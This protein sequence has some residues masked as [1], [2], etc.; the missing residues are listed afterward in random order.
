M[1]KLTFLATNFTPYDDFLKDL[2]ERLNEVYPNSGLLNSLTVTH[3]NIPVFVSKVQEADCTC[4]KLKELFECYK[5]NNYCGEEVLEIAEQLYEAKKPNDNTFAV[6]CFIF[7]TLGY[8]KDNSHGNVVE[9]NDQ[10]A[11]ITVNFGKIEAMISVVLH[12]LFVIFAEKK[13]MVEKNG[14]DEHL[15]CNDIRCFMHPESV[16][17]VLCERCEERLHI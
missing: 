2:T 11:V 5:N 17:L 4:E 1:I 9:N 13:G 6:Y 14:D 10:Y 3:Y 15:H 7:K 8:E 16:S 12:E